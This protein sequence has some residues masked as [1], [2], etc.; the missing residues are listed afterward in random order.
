MDVP[1][2][3]V[4]EPTR[5]YLRVYGNLGWIFLIWVYKAIGQQSQ[6]YHALRYKNLQ[7]NGHGLLKNFSEGLF[8]LR[9]YR[10]V[11]VNQ[12]ITQ[13]LSEYIHLS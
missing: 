7:K 9:L 12:Q 13:L 6:A 11:D 8:E 5:K 3:S 1:T 4:I 2:G 10:L